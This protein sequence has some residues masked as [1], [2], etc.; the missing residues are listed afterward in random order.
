MNFISRGQ[1]ERKLGL[2]YD[3]TSSSKVV[4]LNLSNGDKQKT[5][6]PKVCHNCPVKG[7]E[8]C[9]MSIE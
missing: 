7:K 9:L 1:L 2:P 5:V 8:I 6:A 4:V 3:F